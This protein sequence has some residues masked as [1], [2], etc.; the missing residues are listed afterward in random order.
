MAWPVPTKPSRRKGLSSCISLISVTN[1]LYCVRLPHC[2]KLEAAVQRGSSRARPKTSKHGDTR[3]APH[4]T[5]CS[6]TK[7][8]LFAWFSSAR[9]SGSA[10]RSGA[11][12]EAYSC[13]WLSYLCT[14]C[15]TFAA[16]LAAH[17]SYKATG[18]GDAASSAAH[19]AKPNLVSGDGTDKSA[20]G[21]RSPSPPVSHR[22]TKVCFL[23]HYIHFA[24]AAVVQGR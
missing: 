11:A 24:C 15:S 5:A 22:S 12:A 1:T 16:A 4:G 10:A 21:S 7:Q 17:V 13:S 3:H 19:A 6:Q 23:L 8:K 18:A 14:S 20:Q 9:S 2:T